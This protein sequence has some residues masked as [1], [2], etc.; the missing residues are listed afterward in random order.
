VCWAWIKLQANLKFDKPSKATSSSSQRSVMQGLLGVQA[1]TAPR[2]LRVLLMSPDQLQQ[3]C[4][5]PAGINTTTSSSSKGTH[6]S[7]V[8]AVDCS[9]HMQQQQAGL[10]KDNARGSHQQQQLSQAGVTAAAAEV[11]RVLRYAGVWKGAAEAPV[12]ASS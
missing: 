2:P 5:M 9:S 1:S 12:G 3:E 10:L 6:G 11:E 7:G 4:S 8:I